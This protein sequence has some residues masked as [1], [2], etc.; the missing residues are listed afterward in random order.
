[1]ANSCKFYALSQAIPSWS[2]CQVLPCYTVVVPSI[3]VFVW[4]PPCWPSQRP[5][6]L[7]VNEVVL[8]FKTKPRVLERQRWTKYR[9][10]QCT[11]QSQDKNPHKR[12]SLGFE[13]PS[14]YQRLWQNR[15]H[16][17]CCGH[18]GGSARKTT[19]YSSS[20]T[21]QTR[22]FFQVFASPISSACCMA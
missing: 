4:I 13:V 16:H 21:C 22:H 14:M 7:W 1:M 5:F 2:F 3:G 11:E 6:R 20:I 10:R 8:L 12:P 15:F 19:Q 9:E 17:A 18:T